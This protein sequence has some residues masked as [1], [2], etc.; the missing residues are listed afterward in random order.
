M[1]VDLSDL[2]RWPDDC[3]EEVSR[4]GRSQPCE[5]PAVAVRLDPQ[6]GT[7]YPVCAYHA[8]RGHMVPLA[9]LLFNREAR[10]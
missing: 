2:V 1:S 7:P 4:T 10:R 9:D 3:A 8:S 5:K 6:E